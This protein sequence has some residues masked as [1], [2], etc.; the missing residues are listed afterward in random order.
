MDRRGS[1][2]SAAGTKGVRRRRAP[3]RGMVVAL[4]LA[5]GWLLPS[6]VGTAQTGG[7]Q[8]RVCRSLQAALE[9]VGDRGSAAQALTARLQRFGCATSGPTTTAA[10]ATTTSVHQD[11]P[12]PGGGVGPCPTSTTIV[13][14]DCIGPDGQFIPCPST[15][16]GPGT[17]SPPSTIPG[18][19]T[20]TTVGPPPGTPTTVVTTPG[21]CSSTSTT[22]GQ[23]TT[24][25][26]VP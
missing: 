25:P 17:T 6:S 21:P 1:D 8:P 5:L 14:V 19:S 4:A 22:P 15:T 12:L 26:C 18:G 13:V 11:C 7:A 16:V 24:I 3:W 9:R 10:G 23:V 2:R 20:T